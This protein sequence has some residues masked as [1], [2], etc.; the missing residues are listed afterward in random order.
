MFQ[1]VTETPMIAMTID[2]RYKVTEATAPTDTYHCTLPGAFAKELFNH[3]RS[4]LA[5][6][7]PSHYN[8][9]PRQYRGRFKMCHF[10]INSLR[11]V[12]VEG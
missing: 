3:F 2:R 5:F 6:L 7:A 11:V 4:P 8:L 1:H 10:A 12:L 9:L